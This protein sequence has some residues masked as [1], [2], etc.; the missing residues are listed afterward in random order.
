VI[1]SAG[2]YYRIPIACINDPLSYNKNDQLAEM[3]AKK[4]PNERKLN[5]YISHL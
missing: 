2:I 1:D 3:K 4:I 5:V